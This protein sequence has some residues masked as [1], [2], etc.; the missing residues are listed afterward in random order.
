MTTIN[1]FPTNTGLPSSTT[2]TIAEYTVALGLIRHSKGRSSVGKSLVD[3]H[4]ADWSAYDKRTGRVVPLQIKV[5]TLKRFPTNNRIAFSA[6]SDHLKQVA[7][8][9]VLLVLMD[10]ELEGVYRTWLFSAA[11]TKRLCRKRKRGWIPCPSGR[12]NPKDEYSKYLDAG[13]QAATIR[14]LRYLD[15][16]EIHTSIPK[17]SRE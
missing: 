16:D 12:A 13:L 7:T 11:E 9:F 10:R 5:R 3:D 15:D 8:H 14:L 6:I 4:G 1:R 2:G 17:V